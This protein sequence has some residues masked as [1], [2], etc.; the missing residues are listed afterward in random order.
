MG[1]ARE[2]GTHVDVIPVD[3]EDAFMPPDG[4][5]TLNRVLLV[6]LRKVGQTRTE[7]LCRYRLALTLEYRRCGWG[8][9]STSTA[10]R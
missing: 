7:A 1:G 2:I 5:L 3:G 4:D 9:F 6:R 10:K 8:T